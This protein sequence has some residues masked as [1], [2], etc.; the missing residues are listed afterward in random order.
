MALNRT[1]ENMR[2]GVRD[3]AN[4]KGTSALARHPDATLNEHINEALGLL[5]ARLTSAMP[6]Q[7]ILASTTITTVSGVSTYALPAGFDFLISI[8]LTVDGRRHWLTSYEMPERADIISPD[9]PTLGIPFAY[10]LRGGNIELLPT[11]DAG[12]TP[13]LWYTP[14]ATQLTGDAQTLDTIARLDAWVIG[15]AAKL[16]ATKDKNWDLVAACEATCTALEPL[17]DQLGRNRDRNSPPRI[18][19]SRVRSRWGRSMPR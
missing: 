14:A 12:Y 8:E 7:R 2:D 6:D 19:D 16:V 1:R 13:L 9:Q 15:Y 11:P 5:H 18:I 17:I 10:R 4:I 3:R